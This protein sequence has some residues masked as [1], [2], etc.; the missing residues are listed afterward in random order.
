MNDFEDRLP[1]EVL[2]PGTRDPGFWLRFHGRVLAES[3]TEL[4]R[5]RMA[6][7]LSVTDVVFAW[8]RAL[9]PMALL[10]AALA[11][12]ITMAHEPQPP[13]QV[14]ALEEVLTEDLN[15]LVGSLVVTGEGE[16]LE[17]LFA[18]VEGGF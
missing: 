6:V 12:I 1:L 8:R 9:V 3:Q 15:L 5:R 11:G 7:D 16:V 17:S 4:A 18:G 2:D 14:L 10:A 13:V